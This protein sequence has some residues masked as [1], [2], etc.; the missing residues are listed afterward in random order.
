MSDIQTLIDTVQ[1]E[2]LE[3]RGILSSTETYSELMVELLTDIRLNIVDI[4][5]GLFDFFNAEQ[6]RYN[7]SRLAAIERMRETTTATVPEGPAASQQTFPAADGGGLFAG[8]GI[9]GLL[10]GIGAALSGYVAGIVNNLIKFIT[11]GKFDGPK[12]IGGITKAMTLLKETVMFNVSRLQH[13][14][15][16]LR[17]KLP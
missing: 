11:I 15:D 10:A 14:L 6:E 3:T 7:A 5:D 9:A 16:D 2:S 4:R 12:I 1:A 17:G 13:F 8:L